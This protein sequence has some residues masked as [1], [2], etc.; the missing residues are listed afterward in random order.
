MRVKAIAEADAKKIQ[1]EA[2]AAAIRAKGLAEAE[3]IKAKGLAEAEA[4]DRLAEAMAKYGEA[5]IVEMIVDKLP[6]IMKEIASP[7][8]QIDK[9]TVID[10]GGNQGAS[11]V[12]KIVTDVAANGFEVLKDLTG[13]DISKVLNDFVNK[14]INSNNSSL[15][16]KDNIIDVDQNQLN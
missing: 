11:K 9:L 13:V 2:E 6:D 1:A 3:A 16:N 4:K 5:A 14:D 8:E 12:S 10:N 15:T 7:L